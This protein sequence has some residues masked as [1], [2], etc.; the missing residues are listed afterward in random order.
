MLLIRF[1]V[2]VL[3]GPFL[4]PAFGVI[5]ANLCQP[6]GALMLLHH[7]VVRIDLTLDGLP[8]VRVVLQFSCKPLFRS[9]YLVSTVMAHGH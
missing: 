9:L 5:I 1:Y 2:P 6:Q 7:E 8:K 3:R 4:G